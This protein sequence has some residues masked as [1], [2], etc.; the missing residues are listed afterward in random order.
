MG[1]FLKLQT[2]IEAMNCKAILQRRKVR[3]N[4]VQIAEENIKTPAQILF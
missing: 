3:G 4:I 1:S 2:S